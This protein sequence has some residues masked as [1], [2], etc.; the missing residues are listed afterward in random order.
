MSRKC[1]LVQ[2]GGEKFRG[3]YRSCKRAR[4]GQFDPRSF[5]L[6]ARGRSR[7]KT[8]ILVACPKGKWKRGRCS[9]GTRAV[10]IDRPAKEC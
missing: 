6:I 10:R 8:W 3:C 7:R 5:R 4:E 9:V 2:K 1:K